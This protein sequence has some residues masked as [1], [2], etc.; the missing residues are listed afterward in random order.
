VVWV[1]VLSGSGSK[2]EEFSHAIWPSPYGGSALGAFL[3]AVFFAEVIAQRLLRTQRVTTWV[4]NNCAGELVKLLFSS[5]LQLK[6]VS[7]TLD[8]RKIYIGFVQE[9][10]SLDPAK[11]FVRL[12][13]ILSGY[14]DEKDLTFHFTTNYSLALK[15]TT[16][17]EDF[18]IVIPLSA[19]KTAN[20]FNQN[21]HSR[22]FGRAVLGEEGTV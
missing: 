2:L 20:L 1:I 4:I 5:M 3:L 12:L 14:R 16:D 8:T 7:V 9:I 10:P 13:P 15:E 17:K 6:P 18:V 22:L 11:A 21:T 19:V